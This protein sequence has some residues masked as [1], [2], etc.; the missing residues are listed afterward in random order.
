[1]GEWQIA[2]W[3]MTGVCFSGVV[4]L[5]TQVIANDKSMRA[6]YKSADSEIIARIEHRLE[7]IENKIDDHD[8]KLTQILTVLKQ[9]DSYEQ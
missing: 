7:S 3:A 6:E 9:K 1:M 8:R 2:F 4:Y 5:G